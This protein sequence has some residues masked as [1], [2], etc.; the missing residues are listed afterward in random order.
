MLTQIYY[1]F[2]KSYSQLVMVKKTILFVS[3]IKMSQ[4]SRK[5]YLI[6]LI[7]ANILHL[8]YNCKIKFIF[9][10][11]TTLRFKQITKKNTE[12]LQER[13]IWNQ[14]HNVFYSAYTKIQ[15]SEI[16]RFY[17]RMK[18]W[19]LIIS[20]RVESFLLNVIANEVFKGIY[21][22]TFCTKKHK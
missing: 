12:K 16:K 6:K 15:V 4:K 8:S 19:V 2:D 3:W 14:T 9:N 22:Q 1:V 17:I 18:A 5:H 21:T 13:F 11:R 10:F 7:Y 20:D